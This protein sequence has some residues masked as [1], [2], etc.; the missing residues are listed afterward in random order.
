V[1]ARLRYRSL[2]LLTLL[3]AA[4]LAAQD[5]TDSDRQRG[6][7]LD[8]DATTFVFDSGVYDVDPD[9]VAVTGA[10]RQWSANMDDA[11][12]LLHPAGDALWTLTV[13]NPGYSAIPPAT[14]FKFRV[15]DARGLGRWLDPPAGAPNVEGGNLVFLHGVSPPRL[16][17][18]LRG[19]RAVWATVS[20]TERPLAPEHYRLTRADGSEIAV[21]AVLPNE[22]ETVLVVP[23]EPLDTRRVHY[24]HVDTGEARPLRAFATFDGIFRTLYSD[25]PL[26][27]EVAS[28]A[29]DVRLFAPRADSVR[30]YFY[31][32]PAGASRA[33]HALTRDPQGVW[34]VSFDADLHGTWYD[35][36][37]Y[38]PDD[39]GNT[40]TNHTGAR[41]RDP[42]AR[43]VSGSFGRGRIWRPTTPATPLA[44]GRPPMESVI[45]YEVH[46]QDFTDLLPVG[47][48]AGTIPAMTVT[49]LRNASGAPIGFDH[50]LELGI[51]TVHLMPMQEY[52]HY[53]DDVWQAA[54]ADD[55]FMQE[56]G[57]ARENYQWGYRITDFFAIENRYRQPGTEPGMEREQF[58]D[59]V[60]AF[61]DHGIAVIVDFVFNHTGE[62][63]EGLDHIMNFNGIDRHYY[64]R[65]NEEG[66][67]IGPY[68]N[69][70]KSEERPMTQRWLIDQMRHF[71]EEFGVD[72]FRIDLAGATD[73]QSLKAVMAAMPDDII[74]YGEPWIPPSDPD[75]VANPSWS[76]YKHNAPITFFQDDARNAFKG[77]VSTPRDPVADRGFAGGDGT[78]REDV[79]RGLTNTFPD[80]DSPLAGINYLDIH[81]NW[82]LADQFARYTDGPNAWDGRAGVDEAAV[83][84]AATLLLTSLGPVV[85][86]GGTEFFRSKGLAPHPD[87]FGGER[88]LQTDMGPIYLKGRGDTYNLRYANHFLWETVGR[89]T[90]QSTTPR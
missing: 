11:A 84:I 30:V 80:E 73:R 87:E 63:M 21:S 42:Y 45:A 88:I 66:G 68:G 64:Y 38:G 47:E 61:H 55:P 58:R 25:K 33:S 44:N 1:L 90:G 77:P 31:D 67:N 72:G 78:Q 27:A 69:E 2:L 41:V 34:E 8:G 15:D 22:A 53:P 7:A 65:L 59:L 46:V 89:A 5:V 3:A 75:V 6:Y 17:A 52:L 16:R 62:N 86:H 60:Q 37:V 32:A 4:P 14:P 10:F 18:E 39:P 35:F 29:T 19:E 12:W 57:V 51:N 40:F 71:V 76:W 56:Q 26:G 50:L 43:V 23:A 13:D 83:R 9:R 54:F 74:V 49:G 81:D 79:M 20:G 70:V 24:L 85:M 82:A 48:L 36:A 28:G